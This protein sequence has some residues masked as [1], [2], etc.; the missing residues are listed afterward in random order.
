MLRRTTETGV[1]EIRQ[2][3]EVVVNSNSFSW[4][5]LWIWN[6]TV[7]AWFDLLFLCVKVKIIVVWIF[8][9]R[10]NPARPFLSA[11]LSSE[12]VVNLEIIELL[13]VLAIQ[14]RLM[15]LGVVLVFESACFFPLQERL[16][17]LLLFT[18]LLFGINRRLLLLFWK[19]RL[20][21]LLSCLALYKLS[22]RGSFFDKLIEVFESL[23]QNYEVL[24]AIACPAVRMVDL[25]HL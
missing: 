5:L 4:S 21:F 14:V 20:C 8:S 11:F 1:S 7:L 6:F 13:F 3:F 24:A 18:L 17:P 22:R 2:Q 15:L 10:R 23:L 19:S 25:S 12:M 16:I 9:L